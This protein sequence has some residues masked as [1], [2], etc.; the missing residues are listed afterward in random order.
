MADHSNVGGKV[1]HVLHDAIRQIGAGLAGLLTYPVI[2]RV[3]SSES[4][5]AWSILASASFLPLLTDLGLTTAVQRAAVREDEGRTHRAVT[6]ALFFVFSL[7]P[8]V[9]AGLY[10]F[11]LDI[12]DASPALRADVARAAW[13]TL[14]GGMLAAYTAPFR[15]FIIVRGRVRVAANARLAASLTQVA[16]VATGIVLPPTLVVPAV[17]VLLGQLAETILIL[18]ATREVDPIIPLGPRWPRIKKEILENLR[19]G[20]ATL[21]SNASTIA[22]VRVDTLVLAQVAPLREVA[23]YGVA[24][25]AVD[26]SYVIASQ[27]TVALIPRLRDAATRA[28]S[29]RLG[30]ILYSGFVVCGM[31]ALALDGQQLLVAWVGPVAAGPVTAWTAIL[32]GTAMAVLSLQ[33]VATHMLVMSGRTAWDAGVPKAVG[34]V[35][36]LTLS[37]AG[38]PYFGMWA[39]AGSTLAG[40]LVHVVLALR[41]AR[42]LLGWSVLSAFRLLLPVSAAAGTALAVGWAL[43]SFAH[44]GL[45]ASLAS[46]VL[47]MAAGCLVNLALVARELR[48]QSRTRASAATSE[49]VQSDPEVV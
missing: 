43:A 32:L 22:A 21:T 12:G 10:F 23:S 17:G 42:R 13:V 45:L 34:G 49:A 27:S 28:A 15:G 30:T 29:F 16:V 35:V 24:L 19:D 5:G 6:L 4:L 7:S 8:L 18:R 38:A 47:T 11:F 40:N 20:A 1:R 26:Q 31:A 39:V 44:A 37:I 25:R 41:A 36:N 2:A 9:V 46:C 14:A 33:E 3:V 48:V